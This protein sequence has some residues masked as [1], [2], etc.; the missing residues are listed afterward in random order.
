[1]T[2]RRCSPSWPDR[3]NPA[4]WPGRRQRELR[5]PDLPP[6]PASRLRPVS[7]P[8]TGRPGGQRGPGPGWPQRCSRWRGWSA[9]P[10]RTPARCP[11]PSSRWRTS[12]SAH[13]HRVPVSRSRRPHQDGSGTRATAPPGQPARPPAGLLSPAPLR[14][15]ARSASR[16]SSRSH[17][18]TVMD[19][20]PAPAATARGD[21]R[22]RLG[23]DPRLPPRHRDRRAPRC[24][25]AV[26]EIPG[27]ATTRQ[28]PPPRAFPGSAAGRPLPH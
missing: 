28:S 7:G 3:Q 27:T 19:R 13:Q 24:P 17:R 2:W 26:R 14:P 12:R 18:R 6:R 10:R 15:P 23:R 4:S 1:M 20:A 16:G 21:T 22:T 11:A 25:D 9:S 8:G 5:S